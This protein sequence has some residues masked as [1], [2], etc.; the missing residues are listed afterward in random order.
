MV[1]LWRSF[2][3]EK[4]AGDM[5]GLSSSINDQ[6][7]FARVVRNMLSAM[8]VA[9]RYGDED[10]PEEAEDNSEEEQPRSQEEEQ[11]SPKR[12]PA[13]MPRLRTKTNLPKSRWKKGRWTGR[14]SPTTIS[15]TK[16]DD[17]SETPGEV[18]RPAQPF[19]D[20]NEKVDYHVFSEEFDETTT[21]E[22]LC[23]EAELDRCAP[24]STSSS[25]I[26]RVLS[27]ALPTGCSAA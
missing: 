3:E 21:A 20:F 10:E 7:A 5:D 27:G 15:R 22:D 16:G 1:D 11:S 25:P 6:Q 13:R 12:M 24:S 18:K 8:D 17:D 9:E 23:D 19:S 4:A 2:I 14:R 26:C